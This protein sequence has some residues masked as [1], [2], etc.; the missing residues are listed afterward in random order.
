LRLSKELKRRL[1]NWWFKKFLAQLNYKAKWEGIEVNAVNPRGST[2]PIC[3]SR[4]K[5]YLN[6]QVK[7]RSCSYYVDR[8]VTACLNLLKVSD[9]RLLFSLERPLGVAVSPALTSVSDEDKLGE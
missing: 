2:C 9:V 5:V 8:H 7:C 1:N 6:G 3:G 4:L